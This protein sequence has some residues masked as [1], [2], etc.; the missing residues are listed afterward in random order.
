[1]KKIILISALFFSL[2]GWAEE[3]ERKSIMFDEINDMR[4][5]K[6]KR[7]PIKIQF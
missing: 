5:I 1:M 7:L 4:D 6:D 3:N 2:N